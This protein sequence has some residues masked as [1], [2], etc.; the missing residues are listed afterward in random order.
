MNESSWK[1][2]SAW[3][4]VLM[5]VTAL[6]IVLLHIVRHGTAREADEGTSAHLWQILMAG[7]LPIIAFFAIRWLPRNPKPAL[8]VLVIQAIAGIAALTPVYY[9]GL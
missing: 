2:P 8:L 7:Q 3:L 9:L 1:R 4:P 6:A 5:S